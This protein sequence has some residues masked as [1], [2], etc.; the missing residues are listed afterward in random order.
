MVWK[1]AVTLSQLQQNPR[2]IATVNGNKILFIW[3]E[4]Q[5]HAIQPNCPHL[6][7]PLAK[8]KIDDANQLTCPLHKSVFDLKTGEAKCWSPW[9]PIVG[10]M[11]GKLS[12]PKTLK[13]YPTRVEND[14][15][16][17]EIV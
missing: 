12:K 2:Q 17:V 11:L 13:V 7:F 5:I 8:G 3:H 4:E 6:K 1:E 16:W 15:V 14:Q 10:N 9:P